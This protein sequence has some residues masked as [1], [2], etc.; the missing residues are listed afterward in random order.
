MLRVVR[1]LNEVVTDLDIQTK[2]EEEMRKGAPERS[3]SLH[4]LVVI[5]SL[6]TMFSTL[7]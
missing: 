1:N 3:V 5:F 4:E 7:I 6:I 2:V